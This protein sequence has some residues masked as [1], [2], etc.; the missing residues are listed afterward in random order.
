MN[1]KLAKI[2]VILTTATAVVLSGNHQISAT[3]EPRA[4]LVVQSQNTTV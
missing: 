4:T 2:I 3:V 1:T